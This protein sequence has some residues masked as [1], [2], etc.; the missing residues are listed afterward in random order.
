MPCA[1][2]SMID[3]PGGENDALGIENLLLKTQVSLTSFFKSE[4]NKL[5]QHIILQDQDGQNNN[6]ELG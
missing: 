1:S 4:V 6:K 2:F 5:I 3:G